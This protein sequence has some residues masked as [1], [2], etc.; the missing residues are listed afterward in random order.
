MKQKQLNTFLWT[1]Q[2]TLNN[3]YIFEP[4]LKYFFNK[5]KKIGGSSAIL[6]IQKL[7]C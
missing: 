2:A 3:K 1:V 6:Y 5:K 7:C 4:V